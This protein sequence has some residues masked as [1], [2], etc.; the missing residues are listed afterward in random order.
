MK[1][2]S[3][4]SVL[5]ALAIIAAAWECYTICDKTDGNTFSATI[6]ALGE[7]Q[8][9]IPFMLGMLMRHLWGDHEATLRAYLAG[10]ENGVFWPLIDGQDGKV[11]PA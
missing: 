5:Y 7:G 11:A 9:L 3:T 1:L 6:R 4:L 8:P 2:P 10:F